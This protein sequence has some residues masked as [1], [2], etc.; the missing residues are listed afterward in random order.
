MYKFQ[1]SKF[2]FPI[3]NI[4]FK[5]AK[6]SFLIS[7]LSTF[8]FQLSTKRKGFTFLEVIITIALLTT[9][10]G[11][12]TINLLSARNKASLNSSVDLLI[13]DLQ[14]QQLKALS[15]NTE[16]RSTADNYGVVIGNSNYTMFHGT[17]SQSQ[18][19]NIVVNVDYPLTLSTTFP[20]SQVVFTKSTGEIAGF[21]GSGQNTITVTD[22]SQNTHRTI[23]FNALGIITSVD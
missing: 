19:S 14:S 6:F 16:G 20:N 5:R 12:T 9:I 4:R 23:H 21:A 11:L 17:Y 8:N 10:L 7:N 15:A 13:T 2:Q 18:A 22:S 1:I 3:S